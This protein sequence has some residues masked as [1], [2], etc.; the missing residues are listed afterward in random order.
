MFNNRKIIAATLVVAMVF[1]SSP[2]AWALNGSAAQSEL[3]APPPP[4]KLKQN[5]EAV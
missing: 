5:P 1:M 2:T 4:L 3:D